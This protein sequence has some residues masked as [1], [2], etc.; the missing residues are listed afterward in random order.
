MEYKIEWKVR[1]RENKKIEFENSQEMFNY[2]IRAFGITVGS[3]ET[4]ER[5][6]ELHPFSNGGDY[7]SI[8]DQSTNVIKEREQREKHYVECELIVNDEAG[9]RINFDCL[10]DLINL[11]NVDA[12]GVTVRPFNYLLNKN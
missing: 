6:F 2:I 7:L 8:F 12:S 11:E 3:D 5:T 10:D 9:N 4:G 1:S